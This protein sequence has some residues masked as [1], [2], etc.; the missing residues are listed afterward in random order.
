MTLVAK[1]RRSPKRHNGVT[2]L[3]VEV[4]KVLRAP[5]EHAWPL[6]N[7]K[8][9]KA[10]LGQT[11]DSTRLKKDTTHILTGR[12]TD[13]RLHLSSDSISILPHSAALEDAIATCQ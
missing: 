1:V 4:A 13:S 2:S 7:S 8:L 5:A 10:L 3:R 12:V 11:H 9:I 6:D